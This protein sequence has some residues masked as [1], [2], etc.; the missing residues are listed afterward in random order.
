MELPSF[1]DPQFVFYT[2]VFLAVVL[3]LEGGFIW[4]RDTY[5]SKRRLSKR[6]ELI[7]QGASSAEI[8]TALRRQTTDVSRSLLPS[9]LTYLDTRMNQAGIRLSSQ[10]M[11][12]YM[13]S[14]TLLIGF[15]F[16]LLGGITGQVHSVGAVLLLVL[17]AAGIGIALPIL[18]INYAAA[19]RLKKIEAQFPIALDVL[20]RGLRAGYPVTGALE[21]VVSE[22][23]DPLS[24]ELALVLAEMN[25][26][27]PLR[28]ALDNLAGRVQTQ[29]INMFVVSVAIQTETGGS[30]ADILDGLAR[31]IRDRA[32]M[33]LKVRALASEGKMTGTLLTAMPIL[34][35]LGVF[36]SQPRFYLDVV[37]DP[38]FMPG[39]LGVLFMYTL[40]VVIM[41]RL[42]A[43]KV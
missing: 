38:W 24:S 17:F 32:A 23:P 41:R 31:V 18:Y 16:P 13:A 29:D 37:D 20:V 34:T 36:S 2:I 21:L 26:G 15:L 25:Y 3:L 11:L 19:K 28:D 5:G 8:I 33:V 12:T 40:G 30:L 7:E 22:M 14:A 10:R 42:I 9:V 39:T 6:M 4:Y 1:I 35:F 43:I 27:Y